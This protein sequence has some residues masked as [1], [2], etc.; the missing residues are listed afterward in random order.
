MYNSYNPMQ[1]RM[2]N[3]LQQR[4]MIEQQLQNLQQYAN[5]PPININNQVTPQAQNNFDFNGKWVDNEEQAK[6]IANDN[7]PL[8]LF[9][10]NNPYFYMKNTDG[11]LKKFKFEELK[12]EQNNN[13]DRLDKL[14]EKLN[15]LINSLSTNKSQEYVNKSQERRKK[16]NESVKGNDE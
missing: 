15:T 9:D 1:S 10:N 4:A 13:D 8:I 14:E 2:D 6:Q 12:E 5:I 7:K 3:L 11:T 16:Y